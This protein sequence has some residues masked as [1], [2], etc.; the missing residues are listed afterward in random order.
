MPFVAGAI[1]GGRWE[2]LGANPPS[3]NPILALLFRYLGGTGGKTRR[4]L[5]KEEVRIFFI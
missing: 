4:Y 1:M 2:A 3:Q 5:H